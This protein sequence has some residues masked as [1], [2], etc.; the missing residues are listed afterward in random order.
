MRSYGKLTFE[1]AKRPF[2]PIYRYFNRS[3]G[4]FSM[5]EIKIMLQLP[6]PNPNVG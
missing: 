3:I 1:F 2:G 6:S 5:P 4:V